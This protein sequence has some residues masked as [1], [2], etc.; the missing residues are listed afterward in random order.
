MSV[1]PHLGGSGAG[2]CAA[3]SRSG[4]AVSYLGPV[5]QGGWRAALTAGI[6][7]CGWKD[8]SAAGSVIGANTWAELYLHQGWELTYKIRAMIH[9]HLAGAEV[10]FWLSIALIYP[11]AEVAKFPLWCWILI[12][13]C[14]AT[15]LT[16]SNGPVLYLCPILKSIGPGHLQAGNQ[17]SCSQFIMKKAIQERCFAVLCHSGISWD[18]EWCSFQ[19]TV[20]DYTCTEPV[21]IQGGKG[22]W[23]R[24]VLTVYLK[25]SF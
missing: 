6:V 3:L 24:S 13:D 8:A 7:W 17:S 5:P 23:W 19:T 9:A 10:A 14:V 25:G 1:P 4:W 2:V 12:L 21:L 16:P 20:A 22:H 15:G 11:L 18:T